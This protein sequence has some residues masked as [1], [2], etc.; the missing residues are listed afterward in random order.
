MVTQMIE[1]YEFFHKSSVFAIQSSTTAPVVE[2]KTCHRARL[3]WERAPLREQ[4]P[5]QVTQQRVRP[6]NHKRWNKNADEYFEPSGMGDD[7]NL[8]PHSSWL[9]GSA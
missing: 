2:K 4:T 9:H 8:N 7:P 1:I 5:T 3:V 6:I